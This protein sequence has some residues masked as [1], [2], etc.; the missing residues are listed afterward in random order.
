[1]AKKKLPNAEK[2]DPVPLRVV[3]DYR[4]V[5]ARSMLDRYSIKEVR[6]CIDEIGRSGSYRYSCIDL[7]SGFWQME[8]EEESRQY[9]AFSLPGKAAKFNWCVAPIGLQGSPTSFARLMDYVMGGILGV[10]PYIDDVLV[11]NRGHEEHLKTVAEVLLRLRKY[12][13]KLN[14]D[15]SIFWP[16]TVQYLGYTINEEGLTLLVDKMAAIREMKPPGN[17]KQIREF[18]GLANYFRFPIKDFSKM[19]APMT[20]LTK[21]DSGWKE[22][23]LPEEAYQAFLTLKEKLME[24]PIVAYPKREGR[25]MLTTDTCLGDKDNV[26]GL[27]AVLLQQQKTAEDEDKSWKVIAYASRPLKKHE[28]N[29]SA[30]VVEM[31]AA[32]WGIEHFDVYLIGKQ[33]TL[34]T[35]HRLLEHLGTVHTKTLNRLQHLM[36][37]YDF[38]IEYRVGEDNAVA[39]YLSINSTTTD[40]ASVQEHVSTL[41]ILFP[42]AEM[43]QSK[44]NLM[45]DIIR[46]MKTGNTPEKAQTQ[47]KDRIKRLAHD[48]FL[49]K[50]NRLWYRLPGKTGNG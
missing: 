41:N 39:D 5:N 31:A 37:E 21:K 47:Y 10:L 35:D 40:T 42:E 32:V 2:G 20:A 17:L 18:V 43:D 9:T 30:Y 25:F 23:K 44:D 50:E 14:A 45:A 7:T 19:S 24:Q 22:G 36:L 34:V 16:T 38:T 12:G 3:L 29:Y 15:K 1:V 46:Y 8:L 27:G 26:G 28:K 13:L 49:D 11:H 48:S 33:F 6:E 4:G